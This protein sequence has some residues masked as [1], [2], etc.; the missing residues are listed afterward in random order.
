M[1]HKLQRNKGMRETTIVLNA[2]QLQCWLSARKQRLS[3][4]WC[5]AG[6][7]SF[8]RDAL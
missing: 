7:L 6:L 5:G 3:A 4:D 8:M 2:V 1:E